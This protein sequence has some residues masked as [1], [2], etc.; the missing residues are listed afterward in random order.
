MSSKTTIKKPKIAVPIVTHYPLISQHL[1][2]SLAVVIPCYNEFLRLPYDDYLIFLTHQENIKL[3]FIN[4]GS[5]D[6]T[7]GIFK[8]LSLKFPSQIS[9]I[10][11]EK[12]FGKAEAVRQGMLYS[13]NHLNTDYIAYLDA[14]LSVPFKELLRLFEL[15]ISDKK[16]SLVFGS[17]VAVYG[18][19]INRLIWRHY[20]GRIF[21]TFAS[22]FLDM[23]VYDTQCGIK[24]FKK[25]LIIGVFEP[26]FISRWLFDVEILARLKLTYSSYT[27]KQTVREIPLLEWIEK[28]ESRLKAI[29][30]FRIPYQFACIRFHYKHLQTCKDIN[31]YVTQSL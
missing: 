11:L 30:L 17:R 12:N 14:D 10:D 29:D 3:C 31:T 2:C 13:L 1:E 21:A 19:A 7:L 22:I 15:I 4:D 9:I 27:L 26:E 23:A 16:L 5:T 28:G 25:D 20:L 8:E 24:I 6:G 18:S